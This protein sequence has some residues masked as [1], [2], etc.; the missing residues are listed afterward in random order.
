M[1]NAFRKG[2]LASVIGLGLLA[3]NS[4]AALEI[5]GTST[6][7]GLTIFGD[8]LSDTGNVLSLTKAFGQPAFPSFTGAEGRFSNGP[9]WTEYLAAGLG[10]AS[11]GDRATAEP[12]LAGGSNS[13]RTV[14]AIG[15]PG[16]PELLRTV[17]RGPIRGRVKTPTNTGL[18]GSVIGGSGTT[19]H[20]SWLAVR[21]RPT[22]HARLVVMAGANDLRDI[23]SANFATD[24][25]SVQA[26]ANAAT[27]IAQ[28]VVNALSL[29]ANAGARHFMISS[30]P[31]LGL[32]PEAVSHQPGSGVDGCHAQ[33]QRFV[34]QLAGSFESTTIN[35]KPT[36]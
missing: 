33:L 15:V 32:T 8:S 35:G 36:A 28:N 16:G 21:S 22:T 12:S 20:R 14:S 17:A 31:D 9:A 30:L 25:A 34:Q 23:R 29:L 26:R 10:F 18:L 27:G 13:M 19:L 6:Y 3:G 7:S 11:S 1:V 24:A 5:P 4:H 2:L